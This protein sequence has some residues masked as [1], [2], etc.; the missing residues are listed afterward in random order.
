MKKSE[1]KRYED[2]ITERY[3]ISR[4]R[5]EEQRLWCIGQE[6]KT[7][8]VK[9]GRTINHPD[10]VLIV[11]LVTL[12]AARPVTSDAKSVSCLPCHSVI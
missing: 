2:A 7:L 8:R 10:K 12:P 9:E 11:E 3:K 4:K 5:S 6:R 1:R